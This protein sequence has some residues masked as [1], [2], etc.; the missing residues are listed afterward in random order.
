MYIYHKIICKICDLA[1]TKCFFTNR[2][3]IIRANHV[4][5]G[6][7]CDRYSIVLDQIVFFANQLQ[8]KLQNKLQI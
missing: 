2:V 4:P 1:Q 7:W 5:S 6:I 8:N 3:K